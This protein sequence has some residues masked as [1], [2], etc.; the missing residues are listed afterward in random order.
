MDRNNA[1]KFLEILIKEGV[2][3]D[4]NEPIDDS[5]TSVIEDH[6]GNP[7]TEH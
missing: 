5:L 2:K 4:W 1:H 3:A 7:L 6:T